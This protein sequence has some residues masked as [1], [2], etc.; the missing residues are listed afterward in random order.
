MVALI[1]QILIAQIFWKTLWVLV[2]LC[3]CH[4][5]LCKLDIKCYLVICVHPLQKSTRKELQHE[6]LKN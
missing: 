1:A 5:H 2:H 3:Y 4:L 6:V